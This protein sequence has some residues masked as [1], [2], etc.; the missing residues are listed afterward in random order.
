MKKG[1]LIV[2]CKEIKIKHKKYELRRQSING[3]V[4]P[5]PPRENEKQ[6][7]TLKPEERNWRRIKDCFIKEYSTSKSIQY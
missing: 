5:W 6:R 7:L 1:G 2:I 4:Y 3:N